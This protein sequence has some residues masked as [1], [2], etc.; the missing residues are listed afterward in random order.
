VTLDAIETLVG[1][2]T[3]AIIIVWRISA[4][5]QS[6]EQGFQSLREQIAEQISEL[7]HDR[8]DHREALQELRERQAVLES[9]DDLVEKLAQAIMR[10][11]QND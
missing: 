8:T 7:K 4:F 3:T 6:I 10:C 2:G 9:R 1:F 5:K 11:K